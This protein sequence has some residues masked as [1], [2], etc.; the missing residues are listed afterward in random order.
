MKKLIIT[1]II[2]IPIIVNAQLK[3]EDGKLFYGATLFYN[4]SYQEPNEKF[5]KVDNKWYI[6]WSTATIISEG[7]AYIY[8]YEIESML[9]EDSY[10]TIHCKNGAYS[11]TKLYDID[12]SLKRALYDF[13]TKTCS[14]VTE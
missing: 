11:K 8:F 6:H 13:G 10:L 2:T 4:N 14:Y 3:S 12:D 7:Y 5:I 1:L 9:I